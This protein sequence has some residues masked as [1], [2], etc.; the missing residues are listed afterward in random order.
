MVDDSEL[1]YQSEVFPQ[2]TVVVIYP[3][4]ER[5]ELLSQQFEK[6]GHAFLLRDHDMMVVDGA[7]VGQSWFTPDHL[8][9]I[10]AHEAGHY[11]ARHTQYA[12]DNRDEVL[13][14]EADW[15]GYNLLKIQNRTNAAK[16]HREEYKVRYG[17]L[18]EENDDLMTHLNKHLKESDIRKFIRSV[19]KENF[20]SHSFE[21]VVGD[22]VVNTNPGCVHYGSEGIVLVIEDLPTDQGKV[23]SYEVTNDGGTYT[24]GDVLKKPMDQLGPR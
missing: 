17:S 4:S 11:M 13:E 2:I 23:I 18:P 10:Q 5:Y 15:L 3:E 8:L 19:I 9:V 6:S 21:P 14:R 12:H 1:V 22:E 24:I 20:T 16:L 7:A